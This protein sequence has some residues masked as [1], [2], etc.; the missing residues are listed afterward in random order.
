MSGMLGQTLAMWGAYWVNGPINI[1]VKI[2]D[3]RLESYQLASMGDVDSQS[4]FHLLEHIVD[5]VESLCYVVKV[6]SHMANPYQH[7]Q[8]P[9]F[10]NGCRLV[11][12]C[13]KF[14]RN[15]VCPAT[16]VVGNQFG[17]LDEPLLQMAAPVYPVRAQQ[18]GRRRAR[19]V[20]GSQ[21]HSV[22]AGIFN[23]RY[24]LHNFE[25][26]PWSHELFIGF[27]FIHALRWSF[28]SRGS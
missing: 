3:F 17:L 5:A 2:T 15:F 23:R 16:I 26:E 7:G 28:A 27:Q 9:V 14:R 18:G 8:M 20:R 11:C 25:P 21:I 19:G 1:G 12:F 22:A 10:P 6:D 13:K 4:R 24:G